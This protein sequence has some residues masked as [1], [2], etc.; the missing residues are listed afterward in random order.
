MIFSISLTSL[1]AVVRF[2]Y[3]SFV[4]SILSADVSFNK[5][6]LAHLSYQTRTFYSHPANLPVL[7][8]HIFVDITRM[9]RML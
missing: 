4:T 5:G 6:H 2:S 1:V 7:I 3:P 8:E 9:D